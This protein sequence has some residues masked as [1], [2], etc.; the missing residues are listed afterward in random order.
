MT[1]TPAP[2]WYPDPETPATQ[3][4][5]DGQRWTDNRAPLERKDETADILIWMFMAVA[6]LIGLPIVLLFA[7]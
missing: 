3:R 2:G 6:L 7:L 4:F 5:W 1:K